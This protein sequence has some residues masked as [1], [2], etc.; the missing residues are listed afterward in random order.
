MNARWNQVSEK[1]GI[2]HNS[3]VVICHV[4]CPM[5]LLDRADYADTNK[6]VC[7]GIAD[8]WPGSHRR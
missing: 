3:T 1:P 2:I 5:L 4:R 7:H 8:W 6:G